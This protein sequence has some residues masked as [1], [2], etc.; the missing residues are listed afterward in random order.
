MNKKDTDLIIPENKPED[1]ESL[2]AQMLDMQMKIDILKETINVLKKDPGVEMSALT[3][4]EKAV[5]IDALKTKYSLPKLLEKLCISRSSYYYQEAAI[6]AAD[7]Y[8]EMSCLIVKLFHENRDSFGYRKI[9]MLLK[10]EKYIYH[11]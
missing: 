4:R 7:K 1:I 11:Q 6:Y 2:K 8:A 10:Q 5:I 3:N 9:H